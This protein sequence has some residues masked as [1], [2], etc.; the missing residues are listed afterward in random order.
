LVVGRKGHQTR[1]ELAE[2]DARTFIDRADIVQRIGGLDDGPDDDET[3]AG[4]HG[5]L[6]PIVLGQGNRVFITRR[7]NRKIVEQV[8][9]LVAFGK[10]APVVGRDCETAKPSLHE[11]MDEM[12]GCDTAVIQVGADGLQFDC[13]G[14][15]EPRLGSDIL[16]EIGAA[17]ALFGRNFILMVERGVVLPS[18]LQGL[19][20]CRYSGEELDMPA[21][22]TLFKAFNDFTWSRPARPLTLAI[23]ADHAV[24][25]VLRYERIDTPVYASN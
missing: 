1:F 6:K 3:E 9:E 25:E 12:R 21:A 16:I 19:C 15:D 14:S 5:G 10:F 22:M 23:G 8:K 7:T 2:G 20:E 24:P 4:D 18:N 11:V 17:M 13:G